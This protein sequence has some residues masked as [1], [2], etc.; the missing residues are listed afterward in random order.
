MLE[1]PFFDM[2]N[3]DEQISTEQNDTST[4]FGNGIQSKKSNTTTD[5]DLQPGIHQYY[6]PC[7]CNIHRIG[8][9]EFLAFTFF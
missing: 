1:D 4:I 5:A 7:Q 9:D 2:N 6:Y 3:L 8:I